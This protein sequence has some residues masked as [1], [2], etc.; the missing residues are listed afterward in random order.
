[1][2]QCT[3]CSIYFNTGSFFKKKGKL[4]AWCKQCLYDY[5]K[6]RWNRRKAEFVKM[7]GGKCEK[8]GI[9]G[10]PAI[11]DFHH[12]EKDDKV[13][14]ISRK[15]G[16]S[17]EK[18]CEELEKCSLLCA[19]CHRL[20]HLSEVSWNFTQ[21]KQR[22]PKKLKK[23]ACGKNI[24]TG[25]KYCSRTC[26]QLASERI[27]WPSDLPDLVASSSKR[28]VAAILGVSDKAVAKRLAKHH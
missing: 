16:I 3:K 13:F 14:N 21:D 11:F 8:C 9:I 18:L 17:Y 26:C 12:L 25:K 10:H 5:Q 15:R 2:K 4:S 1:M 19:C 22:T 24:K 6:R 20:E 23:C 7:K 28:A 27:A